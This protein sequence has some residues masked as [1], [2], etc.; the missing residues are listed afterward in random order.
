MMQAQPITTVFFVVA[1]LALTASLA[2]A[3]LVANPQERAV[4]RLIASHPGQ[5]RLELV[6]DPYL[7]LVA[8]AKARD[9]AR[10]NYFNHQ[11]PDGYMPNTVVQLTGYGLPAEYQQG[12][13]IESITAG[14]NFN[15]RRAFASWLNSPGHREQIL[16][17]SSFFQAQTRFGVGYARSANSRFKNYYVFIS[18]P[19]STTPLGALTR[20]TTQLFLRKTPKKIEQQNN[21][22]GLAIVKTSQEKVVTD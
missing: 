1:F 3:Q 4:A 18:A 11:D 5:G 2:K 19:P 14:T 17:E 22:S 15:P 12:N 13:N 7:H 6:H 21:P 8:R 10:R 9:M 16:A 20:A